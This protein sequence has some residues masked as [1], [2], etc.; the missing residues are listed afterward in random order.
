MRRLA[1]GQLLP[2]GHRC[3]VCSHRHLHP[4]TAAVAAVVTATKEAAADAFVDTNAAFATAVV[5][6]SSQTTVGC[7]KASLETVTI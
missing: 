2:I 5:D 6:G 1:Q 7:W 3:I 4:S